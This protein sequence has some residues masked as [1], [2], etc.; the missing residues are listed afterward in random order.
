MTPILAEGVRTTSTDSSVW[1]Q[2]VVVKDL[3][4]GGHLGSLP[5]ASVFYLES[6]RLRSHGRHGLKS[7][8]LGVL[9]LFFVEA[10]FRC[11]DGPDDG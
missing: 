1:F 8:H 5:C 6:A 7:R 2:V 4:R 9:T 3:P 11:L 10:G